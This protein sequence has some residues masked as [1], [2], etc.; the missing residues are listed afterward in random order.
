MTNLISL[1]A[2]TL[3][4]SI[5]YIVGIVST[6]IEVSISLY[7]LWQYLGGWATLA[8]VGA[9]IVAMPIESY[10]VRVDERLNSALYKIRDSRIKSLNEI[11][12]GIRVIKF[13]GWEKSF[14]KLIESIREKEL[15]NFL[16]SSLVNS[17]NVL[18]WTI[19]PFLVSFVSF[20]TFFYTDEKNH[21]DANIAFVSL[22][23][24]N[25]LRFPLSFISDIVTELI[26]V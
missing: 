15:A 26:K 12:A 2:E 3:R 21:L 6:P 19:M 22:T 4:T 25:I 5:Y 17:L 23:L 18:V 20:A 11:L 14:E 24:F 9:M 16:K 1:N 7:M 8:G 10:I 13:M